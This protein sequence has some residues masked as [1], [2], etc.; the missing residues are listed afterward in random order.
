MAKSTQAQERVIIGY[1][2][3]G[4]GSYFPGI[5]RRDLGASDLLRFK[6]AITEHEEAGAMTT[7]YAPIYKEVTNNG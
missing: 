4:D 7:L 6:A 2:Y 5:P 1:R 3:I